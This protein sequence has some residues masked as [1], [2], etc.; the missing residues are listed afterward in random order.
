MNLPK[1]ISDIL[2]QRCGIDYTILGKATIE[3]LVKNRRMECN[4]ASNEEY[5]E[6]LL[7]SDEEFDAFVEGL[8]VPET[9]FFRDKEPFTWLDSWLQ[10]VKDS[11][12]FLRILCAPCATGEEAYSIAMTL[13][14]NGWS[15]QNFKIQ[16]IDLSEKFLEQA[17]LGHYKEKSFRD[18]PFKEK[19]QHFDILEEGIFSV[20]EHLRQSINFTKGNLA[21]PLFLMDQHPFD[22][23]FLRNVLIYFTEKAR[24]KLLSAIDRLLVPDGILI[25]GHADNIST[26]TDKF[27]PVGPPRAFAYCRKNSEA[28]KYTSSLKNKH[29]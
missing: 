14:D 21:N 18:T 17:K 23:I 6:R 11:K 24:G 15:P 22:V 20:K 13:I 9:W 5:F 7:S 1:S 29:A 3:T 2:Q 12:P 8:L 28:L 10:N 27:Q 19:P 16:A 25:L 4:I 26:I